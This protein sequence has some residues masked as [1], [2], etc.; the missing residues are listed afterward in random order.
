MF[1]AKLKKLLGI[2]GLVTTAAPVKVYQHDVHIL[3]PLR[4]VVKYGSSEQR[5]AA[6]FAA[7]RGDGAM[8]RNI[9]KRVYKGA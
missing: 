6:R 8:V 9:A 3:R 4:Y 5:K 7:D 1:V 2:G